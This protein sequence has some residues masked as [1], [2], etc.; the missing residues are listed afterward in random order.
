[1]FGLCGLFAT[2]APVAWWTWLTL[3]QDAEGGGLMGA[4]VQLAITAA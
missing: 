4:M 3:P 2:S 1:V